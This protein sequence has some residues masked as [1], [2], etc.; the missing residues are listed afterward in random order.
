MGNCLKDELINIYTTLVESGTI[1]Y[2]GNESI[3]Y[4]EVTSFAIGENEKLEIELNG[5]ETYNIE[6]EDFEK[7]HSKEGVNYHSWGM[8]R[9]F[10][11]VL[12]KIIK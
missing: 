7:N 8:V 1:F 2:Y 4:G 3:S 11:N 6:L 10:D 5:F 9:E 12:G